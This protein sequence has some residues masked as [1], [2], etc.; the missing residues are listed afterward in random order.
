MGGAVAFA[1]LHDAC[2]YVPYR[3]G[4]ATD[5][6]R[7]SIQHKGGKHRL[8]LVFAVAAVYWLVDTSKETRTLGGL[9]FAPSLSLAKVTALR[10][11]QAS[12]LRT[13]LLTTTLVQTSYSTASSLMG[14]NGSY[15][16][17]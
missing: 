6:L 16:S 5:L 11:S 10:G 17:F 9:F 8:G 4:K 2:E 12:I 13:D 15:A 14:Q 1:G 7:G 3:L